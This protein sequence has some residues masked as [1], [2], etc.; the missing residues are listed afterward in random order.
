M[1][2]ASKLPTVPTASDPA[3]NGKPPESAPAPEPKFVRAPV[4]PGSPTKG[5]SE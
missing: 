3:R 4:V 1:I 2:D 5:A